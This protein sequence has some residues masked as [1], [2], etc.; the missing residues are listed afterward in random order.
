MRRQTALLGQPSR[1]DVFG[2]MAYLSEA[3]R[4]ADVIALSEGEVLVLNQQTMQRAIAEMPAVAARVLFNLSL[5][6]SDRLGKT[7]AMLV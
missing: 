5:I 1:G 7:T 6:L 4:T 2:E 3:P